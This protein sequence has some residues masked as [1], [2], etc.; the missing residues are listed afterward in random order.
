MIFHAVAILAETSGET[1]IPKSLHLLIVG[2]KEGEKR[3]KG[4]TNPKEIV[5]RPTKQD[6][7]AGFR[8]YS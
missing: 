6:S 7:K 4:G 3:Q 2:T 1:I 8:A 5:Q